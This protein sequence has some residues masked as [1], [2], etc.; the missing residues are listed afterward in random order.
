MTRCEK[1][2][3]QALVKSALL[4]SI[5]FYTPLVMGDTVYRCGDAYS[6]S[7]ECSQ[8]TAVNATPSRDQH[9][10]TKFLPDAAS[11]DLRDARALEKNRYQNQR[12]VALE[13]LVKRHSPVV[14]PVETTSTE[15]TSPDTHSKGKGRHKH[16]SS[17]FTAVT[18]RSAKEKK[19]T[20]E[21]TK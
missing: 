18:P 6:A 7:P 4:G 15:P 11:Q 17:Y 20:N 21:K 12:Q 3:T 16:A 1:L 8:T 5:C 2:R 19:N 13:P 9:T 14:A 10:S